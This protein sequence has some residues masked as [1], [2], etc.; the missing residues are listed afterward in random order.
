M[1]C[2]HYALSVQSSAEHLFAVTLTI[3][4]SN[5]NTLTLTLP[6]WIPG[7]YMI[8]DFA[9][10]LITLQA[11]ASD[12]KTLLATKTDKQTWQIENHGAGVT[13]SYTVYAFDLSVRTAFL[14][15]EYGFV[16]GTS[17]FLQVQEFPQ[18]ACE[19]T[20]SLP[21]SH[22]H[23][24]IET[25]MPR[26]DAGHY[27]SA[28]YEELIDHP[29]FM[30]ECVTDAITV[31]GVEFVFL[32]SGHTPVNTQRICQDMIPICEHHLTLFGEPAPISRYVFMTLLSDTGFGGLEHRSS[33]ALL[34]PRFDLPLQREGG[35]RTDSYITFLS[36]CCHELFHTWHVKRLRPKVLLSPDLSQEVYTPQLWIYEGF[37]S[38]YDDLTLARTG[39]I[40]PRKYL[41]IVG[42]NLTRL[43]VTAGRKK[44]SVASSSFDAWTK[45]YKQDASAPNN[46]VSYYTKGGII[47]FGLDLLLREKSDGKVTLDHLMQAL[48]AQFGQDELGTEDAVIETV[49]KDTFNIDITDFI[50]KVVYGTFDV[51]LSD[52]LEQIGVSLHTRPKNGLA[53]KGGTPPASAY[54]KHPLGAMI[55]NA[56][57]GVTVLVVLEDGAAC[58]AGLQV[59]DRIIAMNDWVINDVLLQRLLNQTKAS[60]VALTVLRDGRLLNL[61]LPVLPEQDEA[62]Y[63]TIDNEEKLTA[64]LKPPTSA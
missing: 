3:P 54:Q 5:H 28:N 19:L 36:L 20:V 42:Q 64:W 16:N 6:S 55:K 62:C 15:D 53:D 35:K 32:Y 13:L 30:G 10:N 46:I 57:T 51:P 45:F 7:S 22:A 18:L 40:S 49:C 11:T 29:V 1:N 38:F 61:T 43:Q 48:W 27:I 56:E 59:N 25:S 21:Q 39:L 47:A 60:S 58:Q 12:G 37:T 41:E 33:T 44:Q 17:A 34:Y 63:F 8:R 24:H 14:N 23:W 50:N 31:K 52:W 4:P 9:K 2:L 26:H